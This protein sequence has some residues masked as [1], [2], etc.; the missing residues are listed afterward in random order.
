MRAARRLLARGAGAALLAAAIAACGAAALG[1]GPAGGRAAAQDVEAQALLLERQLLC[2]RCVNVRLD[3]CELAI[4]ADMRREIREQLAAGAAGEDVLLFFS[5][6]YGDRVLADLPRS[7]FNL[8][9]FGWAGGSLALVALGGAAALWRLRRGA[10]PAGPP[11]SPGD[12]RWLDAQPGADGPPDGR[13]GS[14]A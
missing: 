9:L 11:P 1:P 4:C 14:G 2:P 7:G 3:Q 13:G 8:V 5:V 10:A 12:E 6:R